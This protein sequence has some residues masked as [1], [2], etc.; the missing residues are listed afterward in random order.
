MQRAQSRG[1]RKVSTLGDVD[2]SHS[3]LLFFPDD[4][5]LVVNSFNETWRSLIF[6]GS[7]LCWLESSPSSPSPYC[8][9]LTN[10]TGLLTLKSG[11]AS[12]RFS[13]CLA[14]FPFLWFSMDFLSVFLQS[15]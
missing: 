3:W 7:C 5:V 9:C 10:G 11:I 12:G 13:F 8:R 14:P 2:S 6:Q 1:L 15:F 4:S